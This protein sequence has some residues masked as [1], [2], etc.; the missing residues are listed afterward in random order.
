MPTIKEME[1]PIPKSWEEFEDISH[2][3]LKIKWDSPDLQKHGRRGQKQ[4]GIDIYG[5]D[6]LGRPV[7]VQCKKYESELTEITINKEIESA[8]KFIPKIS[9]FY[10]TVSQKRDSQLQ[11]LIRIISEERVKLN[12]FGIGIY[13]WEDLIYEVAKNTSE[14]NQYYPNISLTE[15]SSMRTTGHKLLSILDMTYYGLSLQHYYDLI[16][17]EF[18]ELVNEDPLQII[19]ILKVLEGCS[20][21]LFSVEK[22]REVVSYCNELIKLLIEKPNATTSDNIKANL[23]LIDGDIKALQYSLI[24]KEQSLFNVG[25]ILSVWGKK[26]GDPNALPEN[27]EREL[28]DLLSGI[29]STH[30]DINKIEK[31]IADSKTPGFRV[32]FAHRVYNEVRQSI[33]RVEVI[34]LK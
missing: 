5:N 24:G 18:G 7:G 27:K 8:E 21:N 29:D 25:K 28:I 33:V 23:K 11:K 16:F 14:F 2:S 20:N 13:F 34:D 32:D 19:T 9:A 1:I 31:I 6:Y 15:N 3:A 30:I 10:F 26:E 17:S 4:D 12:K 22:G